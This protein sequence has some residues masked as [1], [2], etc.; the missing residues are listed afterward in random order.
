PP[1]HAEHR[2]VFTRTAPPERPIPFTAKQQ[3]LAANP[4]RPLD[5]QSE[6]QIRRTLPQ[7]PALEPTHVRG[8]MITIPAQSAPVQS[9]APAVTQP[10][11]QNP[12]PMRPVARGPE[13][14]VPRP[15]QAGGQQPNN[16]SNQSPEMAARPV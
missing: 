9:N 5:E 7:R 11:Q 3:A 15:P 12:A 1:S 4:G 10:V 2:A 14:I 8:G 13:R 6:Q 16:Q